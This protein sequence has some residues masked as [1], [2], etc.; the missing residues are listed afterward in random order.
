MVTVHGEAQRARLLE[1]YP[2]EVAEQFREV[3]LVPP[4]TLARD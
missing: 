2:S 3:E 4:D 1:A